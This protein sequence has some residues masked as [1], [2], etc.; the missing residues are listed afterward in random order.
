MKKV[1][2]GL[3]FLSASAFMYANDAPSPYGHPTTVPV[4]VKESFHKD[5]PNAS[6]THWKYMN[7]KWEVSFRQPNGRVAMDACYAPE[8]RHI[9]SRIPMAQSAVPVKVVHKLNDKYHG[10][11]YHF[12]RIERPKKRE[13]YQVRLKDQGMDKT[14]Y[15]DKRGHEKSYASR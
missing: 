9:D 11:A 1:I 12:A 8:G 4:A 3:C 14:V 7:D 15:M 6:I 10:T 5:Y 13:L 2:L